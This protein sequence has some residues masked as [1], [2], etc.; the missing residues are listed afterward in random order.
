M[1]HEAKTEL[2]VNAK[3]KK[4][5]QR[6]SLLENTAQT[7]VHLFL[8]KRTLKKTWTFLRR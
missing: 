8:Q 1:G 3:K 5:R 4:N 7:S 2:D 6:C